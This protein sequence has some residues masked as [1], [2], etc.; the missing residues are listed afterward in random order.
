MNRCRG[1]WLCLT[2]IL[3][4]FAA[5]TLAGDAGPDEAE[6]RAK[7]E[8]P[9]TIEGKELALAEAVG[10][11]S[12]Q[13]GAKIR[14][15]TERSFTNP[16]RLWFSVKD[17]KA[18]DILEM[19]C[20]RTYCEYRLRGGEVLI[21]L[22]CSL[23]ESR[24]ETEIYDV[25]DMTAKTDDSPP[26]WEYLAPFPGSRTIALT[27]VRP[28]LFERRL[29]D[30][31]TENI[32][33]FIRYHVDPETWDPIWG[34][35]IS[36]FSRRLVVTH[37][38]ETR[39]RVRRLLSTFRGRMGQH[40]EVE[41]RVFAVRSAE[42]NRFFREVLVR[43]I[44]PPYLDQAAVDVLDQLVRAGAAQQLFAGSAIFFTDCQGQLS[45]MKIQRLLYDYEFKNGQYVPVTEMAGTG[46]LLAL[47]AV[48]SDDGTQTSLWLQAVHSEMVGEPETV[49]LFHAGVI[50]SPPVK[51]EQGGGKPAS[52][53]PVSPAPKVLPRTLY[54]QLP[55]FS[56]SRVSHDLVL[57][58]DRYAAMS[59]PS[60]GKDG[61][62]PGREMLVLVRCR[63][64]G[65][66]K[67]DTYWPTRRSLEIPPALRE[68][69]AR[70]VT[71]EFRARPFGEALREFAAV[72]GAPLVVDCVSVGEEE[73][74]KPISWAIRDTPADE[75]L[76]PL[77]R[78][79]GAAVQPYPSFVFISSRNGIASRR[80]CLRIF[81]V[82]D[83]DW[84]HEDYPSELGGPDGALPLPRLSSC[85][86]RVIADCSPWPMAEGVMSADQIAQL[87]KERLLP[88]DFADSSTSI[89]EQG[90]R[91]IVMN[92]PEVHAKIE[93]II[94]GF[95]Q[96][97]RTFVSVTARWAVVNTAGLQ[98]AIGK[99]AE[100]PLEAA[101][102]ARVLALLEEKHTRLL[103]TA[104]LNPLQG[105][106][107]S[108]FG[109]NDVLQIAGYE[110]YDQVHRPT[111]VPVLGGAGVQVRPFVVPHEGQ[112]SGL[113]LDL[114]L[115]LAR[116]DR[117][118]ERIG[119]KDDAQRKA[120]EGEETLASTGQ[121]HSSRTDKQVISC[122]VHIPDGGA[123][124]FRR[125]VPEWIKG[126]V[127]ED[128]R[129]GKRT[130]IVLVQ[131][132]IQ[133]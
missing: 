51:G 124:L 92:T 64:Q 68:R 128:S 114:Q 10:E 103:A 126:E 54:V 53:T 86:P 26:P 107:V 104:R 20:E 39:A 14:I 129:K 101:N 17:A 95:R 44:A 73:M 55:A 85:Y 37:V 122:T 82:R 62:V 29:S 9:V 120:R 31:P 69:L 113:R 5:S 28:I 99:E 13:T 71:L 106:R 74:A 38:P 90:G 77:L 121:V 97:F 118:P 52:A 84:T 22:V 61:L 32:A 131:A 127:A 66:T 27:D 35:S 94:A 110:I 65:V 48:L 132:E 2:G 19:L 116:T 25:A 70:K 119:P 8:K 75:A 24:P 16:S 57:T 45:D 30:W 58:S 6:L 130:L 87:V 72:T 47:R 43:G 91:I 78:L 1:D 42:V 123:A 93:R 63:P 125:P 100:V 102:T 76:Q 11:L 96:R 36:S 15:L 117:E 109:G 98:A 21:G 23:S 111:V 89:E 4:L 34:T 56:F 49:P 115:T 33:N 105:Q 50:P 67:G 81:D 3:A 59:A 83:L 46:T 133:N 80:L 112:P 108:A 88:A 41:G 60:G 12:R 18:R 7:L 79:G 40:V